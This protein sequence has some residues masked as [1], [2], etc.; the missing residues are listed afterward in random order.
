MSTP[1]IVLATI[2]FYFFLLF[3]ISWITGR[4]AATAGFFTGNSNDWGTYFGRDI[5]FRAGS[6]GSQLLLLSAN[7]VWLFCGLST[8]GIRAYPHVLPNESGEHL[9][10]S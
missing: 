10:L 1:L 2:A 9:R 3:I 8:C 5:Y 4:K 7:G 6:R